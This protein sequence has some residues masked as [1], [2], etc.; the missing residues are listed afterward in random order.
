MKPLFVLISLVILQSQTVFA[1]SFSL[2]KD[3]KN[4]LCTSTDARNPGAGAECASEAYAG[5][6]SK[7]ESIRLCAGANSTAP[8]KCAVKAYSGPFSKE[9]AISLCIRA[10][11]IGPI[12]C[13][14]RAYAGPFSK[15]ES[16]NL[17][18]GNGTLANAECAIKAYSGAYSKE[19]AL[20]L[21]K[22]EPQLM[23]RSLNLILQSAE[24]Q[25]KVR[26]MK[27]NTPVLPQ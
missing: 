3:G 4:Y 16:L 21:C 9:E 23:L 18:S 27:M 11:T 14:N 15:V 13:A 1:D 5:P 20:R 25:Q 10:Q 7:D 8:A 6:F 22:N 17:C 19:E 26:L 2:V 12:D 24:I